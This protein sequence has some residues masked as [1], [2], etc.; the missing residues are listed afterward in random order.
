MANFGT[1]SGEVLCHD[2]CHTG[3]ELSCDTLK[4]SECVQKTFCE[5]IGFGSGETDRDI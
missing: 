3:T 5:V 4:M 1:S 2:C